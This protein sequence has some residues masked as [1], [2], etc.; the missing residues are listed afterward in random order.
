MFMKNMY[1][2]CQ[3]LV[4]KIK[5]MGTYLIWPNMANHDDWSNI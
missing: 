3:Y 2:F 1:I 5:S 4:P